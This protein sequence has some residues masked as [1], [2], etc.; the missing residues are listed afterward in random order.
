MEYIP[1][2]YNQELIDKSKSYETVIFL[3][4]NAFEDQEQI[5]II[6]TLNEN[7][8][9]F[10]VISMRNPYDYLKIDKNINYYTFYEST[11]NSK[12]SLIK[13]LKGEIEATGKLPITLDHIYLNSIYK[14]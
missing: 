5:K 14:S 10:F 8:S 2:E 4:F 1:H 11:P 3:S 13:F 9:N 12:K 6:N 7:C